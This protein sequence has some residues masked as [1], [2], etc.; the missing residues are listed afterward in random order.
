MMSHESAKKVPRT[1]G[2]DMLTGVA[3]LRDPAL[4][5][6]SAFTEAE[7]D[8]LGLR[9]LLPARVHTQEEQV[10]RIVTNLRRCQSDLDKY[11]ALNALRERNETLFFRVVT[12]N[13]EEM[14]PLIYTPTVGTGCLQYGQIFQRPRGIFITAKDRG[15]IA[16]VLRNWPQPKVSMIVVTDGERI[17][18]LGDL[19]AHGMGIP[20][21]KLC[22]YTACAGIH[23]DECLP[24]MLDVGTENKEF[25]KDPMYLGLRQQRVRGPAYDEL[26]DEF[27]TAVHQV[28]P[29]AVIQF[30]DFG[31]SN[32]F[33]LLEK[34][35]PRIC[36]FNDDIQGTAAVVLAGL[37]SAARITGRK[38]ADE[39]ILFLGAGEAAIGICELLVASMVAQGLNKEEARKRLWLVDSKGLVVKSRSGLTEHKQQFAHDHRA[40]PDFQS[41]IESVKPTAIVG[42]AAVRDAFNQQV[43]E[44][45]AR[46]NEQP[47]I[48][49]LSNPTSK[50]ECTA[51]EAYRW[52]NGRCVFACGSPFDPVNVNGR[53]LV[54]R[55]GNNSYI[56]P[57]VGLAA[58]ASGAKR[59]TDEMFLAAARSLADQVTQQEIDQGALYPSLSRVREVSARLATAVA[60]VAYEQ[61][62]AT[63]PR[64]SEMFAHVSSLMY[65]PKYRMFA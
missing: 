56:F 64:P 63:K 24:I 59:V 16:S 10:Q 33:R 57:G 55:Q 17:L 34:Y 35:R 41:A 36:T 27:I 3:L 13:V 53:T 14:M 51:E 32:A 8:A 26:V 21:G 30:E 7:R 31:N 46:I 50:A 65:E 54:P 60:K 62:I 9:G 43:C 2:H 6:G 40:L 25:L 18:G 58:I 4:N 48:F 44:A 5:K 23:P 37:Y 38:L 39:K 52:T 15:R 61:G 47:L 12:D 28:Y 1:P 42:V 20:V 11:I 29:G 45:M 19:G 22:L 49:A